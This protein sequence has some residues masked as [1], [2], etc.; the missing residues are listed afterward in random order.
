MRRTLVV[1]AVVL[2]LVGVSA[3]A[4]GSGVGAVTSNGQERGSGDG[5]AYPGDAQVSKDKDNRTGWVG[6]T[7][8][9][10]ARAEQ[11]GAQARWN[12][13]GTPSVLRST[14]APL[15][16]G[17]ANDPVQAAREYIAANRDLLGLTASGADALEL[18]S[19]APMGAGAAVLFRQRFGDLPAGHDGLVSIGVRDGAVWYVSSSLAR[20]GKAPAPATLSAAAAERI[21]RADAGLADATVMGTELVAVPTVDR[22]ARAAY[23]VVLGG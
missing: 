14:G 20:D 11:L 22:G 2:V 19:A 5:R 23:D 6:P 12:G 4:A 9:Q 15:A 7:A 1:L 16:T 10:H 13:F 21:A 3:A 18:L 17:L 8:S